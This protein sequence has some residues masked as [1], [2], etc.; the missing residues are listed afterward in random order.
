[1]KSTM[2]PS[3]STVARSRAFH[4]GV[5]GTFHLA[6]TVASCP[7]RQCVD[8]VVGGEAQVSAWPAGR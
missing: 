1:V 7:C 4:G 3:G 5:D 8:L 2:L 6:R